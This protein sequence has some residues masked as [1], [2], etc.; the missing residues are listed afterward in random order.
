VSLDGEPAGKEKKEPGNREMKSSLMRS[1]KDMS[2]GY[3]I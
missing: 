3:V 2:N 1:E